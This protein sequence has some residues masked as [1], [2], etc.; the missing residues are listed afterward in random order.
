MLWIWI[1][2]CNNNYFEFVLTCLD[3]R[4][5]LYYHNNIAMLLHYIYFFAKWSD[6]QVNNSSEVKLY[7]LHKKLLITGF[8]IWSMTELML[9]NIKLN[10]I[11]FLIVF[12][13]SYVS[14]TLYGNQGCS[15]PIASNIQGCSCATVYSTRCIAQGHLS[16]FA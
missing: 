1:Y 2:Y 9:Y 7:L 3:I 8:V 12:V 13:V 11:I 5:Y 10:K 4:A 6:I 14:Y 15:C 16:V